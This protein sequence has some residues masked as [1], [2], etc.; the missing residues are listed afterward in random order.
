[1]H[2]I[3]AGLQPFDVNGSI[4]T[5]GRWKDTMPKTREPA[6]YRLVTPLVRVVAD[7]DPHVE[8]LAAAHDSGNIHFL[9]G[10]IAAV[11]AN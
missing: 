11:G 2:T 5:C 3:P 1:M 7:D 10:N 4:P 6:A 8:R 9:D